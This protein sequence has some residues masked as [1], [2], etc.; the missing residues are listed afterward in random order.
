MTMAYQ[1]QEGFRFVFSPP[2]QALLEVMRVNGDTV[3][4]EQSGN[5]LILDVSLKGAKIAIPM[6]LPMYERNVDI[7]LTFEINPGNSVRVKGYPIWKSKSFSDYQYGIQFT[8]GTYV[9]DGL[10]Q[11]IKEYAKR[12]K[13]R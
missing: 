13:H 10:L 9:Q 7:S 12:Q 2:I 5:A 6:D 1:R 4:M 11:E 3:E 8:A